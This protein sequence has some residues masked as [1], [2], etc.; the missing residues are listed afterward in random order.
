MAAYTLDRTIP[1]LAVESL[2]FAY[3]IPNAP[4]PPAVLDDVTLVLPRGARCILVGANG[5][6]ESPSLLIL[7]RTGQWREGPDQQLRIGAR[8]R[9]VVTL[10]LGS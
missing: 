7:G 4:P 2:H 9:L 1:A 3:S 6:G 10:A 5:A 8:A